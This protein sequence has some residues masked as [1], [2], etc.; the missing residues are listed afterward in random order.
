MAVIEEITG[1]KRS[2]PQ[3]RQFLKSMGMEC[4]KVGMIPAKADVEKQE[5][6][7]K[8]QLEP[9]IEEANAGTRKV[10]SVDA[11]HFVLAPFLGFLGYPLKAGH[12]VNSRDYRIYIIIKGFR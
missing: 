11:A 10:F 7:K 9:L 6:F 1:I 3:V 12:S 8:E 2:E 4:R 5:K